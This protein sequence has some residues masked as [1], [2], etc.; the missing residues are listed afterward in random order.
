M[1]LAALINIKLSKIFFTKK[2]EKMIPVKTVR[3]I[4]DPKS[5]A[6]STYL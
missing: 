5:V 2:L 6:L 4:F 1:H 3:K